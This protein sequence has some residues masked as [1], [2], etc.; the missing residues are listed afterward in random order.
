MAREIQS[1][2]SVVR[3]GRVPRK[4]YRLAMSIDGHYGIDEIVPRHYEAEARAAGLPKGRALELLYDMAE[5]LD[6][7]LDRTRL[8]LEKLVPGTVSDPIEN[9]AMERARQVRQLL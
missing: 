2:S 3:A 6:A 8:K 5:R 7:A 1:I 4:R 9:D